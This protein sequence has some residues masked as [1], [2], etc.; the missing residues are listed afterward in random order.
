MHGQGLTM[1][2]RAFLRAGG[3][4]PL[5]SFPLAAWFEPAQAEAAD[6]V[7]PELLFLRRF[8]CGIRSADWSAI[9]QLGVAEYLAR[10]LRQSDA[11]TLALGGTLFPLANQSPALFELT[12]QTPGLGWSALTQRRKLTLFMAMFSPAQL[13]ERMVEF[14]QD[15]FNTSPRAPERAFYECYKDDR[16]R[17]LAFAPFG[18]L[19]VAVA[20]S[21]ALLVYLDNHLSRKNAINENFARELLE[22]HTLGEGQGYTEEDVREVAR[23]FTGW[24]VGGGQFQFRDELHDAGSKTVLGQPINAG[25]IQDGL[26]VLSILAQHPDTA[27]H[28]ARKYAI[29]FVSDKP[30]AGLVASLAATFQRSGGRPADMLRAIVASSEYQ[31]SAGQKFMRP[32]SFVCSLARGFEVTETEGVPDAKLELLEQMQHL[33][34]GW[35]TPEGFPQGEAFWLTPQTLFQRVGYALAEGS[36][37]Q[38]HANLA[39][40]PRLT[41]LLQLSNLT[42]L[43][44]GS[45]NRVTRLFPLFAFPTVPRVLVR[46]LA[47]RLLRRTL[48]P[49][50]EDAVASHI[51]DGAPDAALPV[52]LAK[53]RAPVAAALLLASPFHMKV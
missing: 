28:L 30:S 46:Q 34:F 47:E 52:A 6:G 17:R 44:S 33:P 11:L 7:S 3:A 12:A 48:P 45:D 51:G 15:H 37:D 1:N 13:R 26:T 5:A 27:L 40:F 39:K 4:A 9:Q 32:R 16:L 41:N 35:L 36:M 14:W 20:K 21:P 22:L 38:L 50:V 10:Q 53:Q 29:A 25:G 19:L 8:S 23:C 31:A 49:A 2:R 18:E 42:G 43:V 24:T